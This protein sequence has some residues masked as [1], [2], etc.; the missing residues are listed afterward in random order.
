MIGQLVGR[1]AGNYIR[2]HFDRPANVVVLG[3]SQLETSNRRMAAMQAGLLEMA[4][5]AQIVGEYAANADRDSGYAAMRDILQAEIDFDV[6]LSLS[7]A[8]SFGAIRALEEAGIAPDEVAIFSVNG[9]SLAEQYVREGYYLR[10]TLQISA[11]EVAQISVDAVVRLLGDATV[12]QFIVL[13]QNAL[14]TR[15]GLEASPQD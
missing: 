6:V 12:P 3:A 1:E 5:E 15:D 7:D 2:D 10:A 14:I 11:A 13:A 4:P 8:T 9:E